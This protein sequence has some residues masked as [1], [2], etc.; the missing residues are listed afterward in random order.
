MMWKNH[1]KI[2]WR[3]IKRQRVYTAINVLGLGIG[4][5]VCMVIYLIVGYEFSFDRFHPDQGRIYRVM[6]E[7]TESTGDKLNFVRVPAPVAQNGRESLTGLETIAELIPYGAKIA[8]PDGDKPLKFYRSRTTETTY[9]TTVLAEPDYFDIFSYQWLV[10]DAKTALASPFA[11]V[12]TE[13]KARQYFGTGPL[14]KML[15]K[16]VI[17]GDS[18]RVSVHGIVKDWDKNTDL[19]FTD[20]ISF[21]T[22]PN[23]YLRKRINT[24]SWQQGDMNAWVFAKLAKGVPASTVNAQLKGM[25]ATYAGDAIKLE[26]RLE[27]ISAL[28]FDNKVIENPIRTAHLPT[29]YSLGLIAFFILLL[30]IINF[31][32]LSTAQSIQRAKE[33]GVRKVLGSSKAGLL[34]QFLTETFVLTFFGV[35]LAILCINPLLVLFKSFIPTGVTFDYFAPSSLLFFAVVTLLTSIL[36]GFYPARVLA[37]YLPAQSL[38]GGG[39]QPGGEKWLL[40]KGLIVFQFS[41]SLVFITGSIVIG[42]QIKYTREKDLG[43]SAD[44]IITLEG[45]RGEDP[46]KIGLLAQRFKQIPGVDQVALQWLAPMTDNARGMKIK[47]QST[48]Q[49]DFWVTQVVGNEDFIPLYGI[50]MLAGRNLLKADSVKEFVI[51]ASFSKFMGHQRPEE[52][53]GKILYWNDKPYPVVGVVSDFHATSLHDPIVPLCI[54]NRPDRQG[55]IGVKLAS[56][57]QEAGMIKT[58]LQQ[59]E[60]TWKSVYPNSPFD[61]QFYDDALGALYLKDRQAATLMNAAMFMAIF[62][63]CIGLLGLTL[64]AAEKRAKEM[65]IRKILGASVAQIVMLFSKDFMAMVI[66]AFLI[67]APVAWYLMQQWLQAFAYHIELKWWMF[68]LAGVMTLLLAFL[69]VGYQ[70]FKSALANPVRSLR[71]E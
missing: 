4:L 45:P 24:V 66:L 2:A 49:K 30:A 48:D 58:A 14:D 39:A 26:L 12:L 20:F 9:P 29:L 27:P 36:A 54:I 23:S 67:A 37:A 51:N 64:F 63:S 6:G 28:H 10:G 15:G 1:F 13:R 61:F 7:L 56:K 46:N 68:V 53:L 19:A 5:C 62:L 22:L 31:I 41:V 71:N 33:V 47:Y 70:S 57:G 16:E 52:S 38:K 65:S 32:N 69:T 21:S 34:I 11:L 42:Q 25:A 8:V 59:L 35:L 18:L 17:Y 50:K 3:N 44:A 55:S 40:R 43:F 60:K